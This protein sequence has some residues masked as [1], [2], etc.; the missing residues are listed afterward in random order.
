MVATR[1]IK[2]RVVR[3]LLAPADIPFIADI[4]HLLAGI[5]EPRCCLK[6][7]PSIHLSYTS[8]WPRLT[9]GTA[10]AFLAIGFS[11]TVPDIYLNTKLM[12]TDVTTL[13]VGGPYFET[14]R[15]LCEPRPSST[16]HIFL[17]HQTLSWD[18]TS[19]SDECR[20]LAYMIYAFSIL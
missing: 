1:T 17:L 19:A 12:V 2:D 9:S 7:A 18:G 11:K 6:Y 15:A 4:H 13:A 5:D 3:N 8:S 16:L 10:L 14:F 20:T